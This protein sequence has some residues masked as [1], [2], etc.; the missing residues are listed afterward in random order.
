M[1]G[2]IISELEAEKQPDWKYRNES[3]K[4]WLQE[5]QGESFKVLSS[6]EEAV[7]LKGV[8]FW[9]SREYVEIIE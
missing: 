9:V 7:R 8:S 4:K 1:K 3:F 6:D 2:K 5:H